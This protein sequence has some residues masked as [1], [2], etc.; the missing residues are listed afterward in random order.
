MTIAEN[1][2]VLMLGK[3][4][5]TTCESCGKPEQECRPYGED[6]NMICFECGMKDEENIKKRFDT[7]IQQ[8][9][10]AAQQQQAPVEDD[11]P[12]PLFR[13][14][15]EHPSDVSTKMMQDSIFRLTR[16]LFEIVRQKTDPPVNG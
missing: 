9:T 13:Q 12:H 4:Q 10:A 6:G 5:V 16:P 1:V 8:A 15:I 14:A 11:T 7:I 2:V 3:P